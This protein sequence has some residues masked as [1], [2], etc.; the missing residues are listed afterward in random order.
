MFDDFMKKLTSINTAFYILLALLIVFMWKNPDI[1]LMLF[2]ALVFASSLNPLVDKLETKMKRPVAAAVVLFGL[3]GLLALFII[4]IIILF[5]YQIT[6]FANDFPNYITNI[7]NLISNS[8]FLQKM[9]VGHINY[10]E[11]ISSTA[12]Y[13]KDFFDGVMDLVGKIGSISLY[14]L[15][16]VI[17]TFLLMSDREQIK[18]S[19]LKLFPSK[20]RQKTEGI[21][22]II[23]QRIGGY[24]IA[25]TC[26][27]TSVGVVMTIGLWIFGIPYALILGLI[28]AILDIIPVV[29]PAIG[30][31]ICL[32]ATYEFGFKALLVVTIVFAL[33]QFIEN[34]FVRPYAFGKLLNLHPMIVF[35]FLF[36][37][38]KYFGLVGTLFAPAIAATICVLVEELYTKNLK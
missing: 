3:I 22:E 26:A 5:A 12:A 29:G 1:S 34:N 36:L 7:N 17:F 16:T 9:G 31:A 20:L 6:L 15:I 33:A 2:I 21:F 30:L 14:L 13:S 19:V 24:V 8:Q 38:T 32:I 23:G 11:M 37:G 28:T 35:I 25:Q 18:K 27:I 10:D 4:P